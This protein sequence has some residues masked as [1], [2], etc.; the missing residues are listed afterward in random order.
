MIALSI[1]FNTFILGLALL[2]GTSLAKIDS[3]IAWYSAF[4]IIIGLTVIGYSR[5]GS[6]F[7]NIISGRKAISREQA[8]LEP[9]LQDIILNANKE[10]ATNYSL[11]DF[12]FKISDSKLANALAISHDTILV[13]TATLD[14]FNDIQLRAILAHEIAYI[15]YHDN[16]KRTALL[17][18]SFSTRI[19]LSLYDL[20]V[21]FIAFL[22]RAGRGRHTSI[23]V[24]LSWIV[25][26]IFL[27]ITILNWLG[28][29][30]F[31]LL[32]AHMS[33]KAEFRADAFVAKLGYA[34]DLISV[35]EI[36]NKL[37]ESD[38]S[39]ISRMMSSHPAYLSRIGALEEVQNRE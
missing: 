34:Q 36:F 21:I 31:K 32:N 7:M 18:S 22:T 19:I 15:H 3:A 35:L 27:P 4:A 1:I 6:I 33:R 29:N 39:F 13:T 14:T 17:F 2:I 8:K 28:S 37:N 26:I 24:F 11:S 10:F 25:A 20:Y 5:L 30:I 16:L 23:I 38:N 12:K 9:L